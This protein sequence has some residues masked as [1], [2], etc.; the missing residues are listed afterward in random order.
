[1]PVAVAASIEQMLDPP[2]AI[3]VCLAPCRIEG[4]NIRKLQPMR[5]GPV[6]VEVEVDDSKS[7]V[8]QERNRVADHAMEARRVGE[9]VGSARVSP[10]RVAK[11][12]QHTSF[13][14]VFR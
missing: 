10:E 5:Y 2:K 12:K 14:P 11:C 13:L 7:A 4:D 1:M 3:L 6:I 8:G 9:K